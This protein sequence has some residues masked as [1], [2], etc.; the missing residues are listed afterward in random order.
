MHKKI[1]PLRDK[2]TKRLVNIGAE[3]WLGKEIK[4]DLL[5]NSVKTIH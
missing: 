1:L 3:K 5:R 4:I 2:K